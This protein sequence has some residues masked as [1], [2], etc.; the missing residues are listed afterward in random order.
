PVVVLAPE[1]NS[2]NEVLAMRAAGATV[3]YYP[4]GFDMQLDPIEVERLCSLHNPGVL[5]VTHYA[6]W[7][8]PMR[9]ILDLARRRGMLVVEDCAR[10]LLSE[11]DGQPLGSFGDWSIFCLYKTLPVPNG[12][13]LVANRP[14]L[15]QSRSTIETLNRVHLRAA[16]MATVA[17]RTAE[18]AVQG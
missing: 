1:Y 15:V 13:A 3:R 8:Q 18:I 6:G 17:G 11:A 12:A 9:Q 2:G 10:A 16:G 5:Y 14:T 4:I 7:P